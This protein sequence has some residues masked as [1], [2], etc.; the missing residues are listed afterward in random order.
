MKSKRL[1]VPRKRLE[2]YFKMLDEID[3][4][5]FRLVNALEKDMKE[6]TKIKGIEFVWSDGSI[7]GIG[8]D[9]PRKME[10]VHR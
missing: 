10:L 3:N 7:I 5:H 4:V 1:K 2:K 8:T 6:Q 9:D